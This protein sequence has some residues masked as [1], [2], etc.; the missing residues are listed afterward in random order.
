MVNAKRIYA[1]FKVFSRGYLSNKFGLFFGLVQVKL[2]FTPKTKTQG[3][4]M[5]EILVQVF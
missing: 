4:L 2:M 1:D 3:C 5:A